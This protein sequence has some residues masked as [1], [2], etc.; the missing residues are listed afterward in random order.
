MDQQQ[1]RAVTLDFYVAAILAKIDSG[2]GLTANCE[3]RIADCG[4]KSA[5]RGA[6]A[7]EHV[8]K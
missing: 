7:M 3:L 2:H 4:F 1:D 8:V 6:W 5:G